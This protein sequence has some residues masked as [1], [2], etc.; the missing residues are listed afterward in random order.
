MG[1]AVREIPS[2]VPFLWYDEC[3]S[4]SASWLDFTKH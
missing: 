2:I 1:K 4:S 3:N